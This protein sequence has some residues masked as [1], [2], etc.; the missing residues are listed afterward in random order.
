[1][2]DYD[3]IEKLEDTFKDAARHQ[4]ETLCAILDRNAGV[5]YLHPYLRGSDAPPDAAAFRRAVP[6]SCYEDY[7]DHIGKLSDGDLVDEQGRH[8]LSVDPL[9]C[10]FYR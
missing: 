9:L 8:L 3:L 7:E 6:L 10:F 1:M 4:R 5:S 2:P